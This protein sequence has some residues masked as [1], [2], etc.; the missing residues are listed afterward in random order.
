MGG[1]PAY[2]SGCLGLLLSRGAPLSLGQGHGNRGGAWWKRDDEDCVCETGGSMD[3][4]WVVGL[5]VLLAGMAY[6]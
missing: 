3:G 4:L 2:P 6:I 1:Q 5:P